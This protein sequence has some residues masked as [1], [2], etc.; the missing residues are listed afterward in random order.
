MF[1]IWHSPLR[2][3]IVETLEEALIYKKMQ[4]A[5]SGTSPDIVPYVPPSEPRKPYF[6]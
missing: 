4:E 1:K 5:A 6:S 2:S 3:I